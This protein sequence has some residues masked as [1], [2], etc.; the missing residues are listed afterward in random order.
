MEETACEIHCKPDLLVVKEDSAQKLLTV[1]TNE[2][3]PI[4]VVNDNF[5]LFNERASMEGHRYTANVNVASVGMLTTAFGFIRHR[6]V[7]LAEIIQQFLA[8]GLLGSKVGS[9]FHSIFRLLFLG[10]VV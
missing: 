8:F 2:T 9:I 10:I 4:S 3:I 1:G 5:R 7:V 6:N